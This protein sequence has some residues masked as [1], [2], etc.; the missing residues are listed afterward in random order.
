MVRKVQ[1]SGACLQDIAA[2]D[3]IQHTIRGCCSLHLHSLT[4]TS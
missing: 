2:H 4:N 1:C 3:A